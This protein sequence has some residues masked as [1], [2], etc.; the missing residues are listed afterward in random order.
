MDVCFD[1]GGTEREG[2][3]KM[4]KSRVQNFVHLPQ[5]RVKLLIPPF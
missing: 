4:G 2:D 3:Y 5:D 1:A